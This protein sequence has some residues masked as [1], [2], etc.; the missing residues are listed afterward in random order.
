MATTRNAGPAIPTDD[1]ELAALIEQD[2][3]RPGRHHARLTETGTQVRSVLGTWRRTKGNLAATA[4]EW[5]IS[6][7]AVQAAVRYYE[8]HRTLFDA[9][10][11][12]QEEEWNA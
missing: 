12:I 3:N 8:Q 6:E 1:Q 5:D 11:L 9:F 4:K 7:A 10:F 2:P